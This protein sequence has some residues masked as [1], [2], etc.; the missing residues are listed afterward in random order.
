MRNSV[1]NILLGT[2]LLW[3]CTNRNNE[4]DNIQDSTDIELT[5]VTSDSLVVEPQISEEIKVVEDVILF[6]ATYRIL[7]STELQDKLASAKWK[8]IHKK[9][10]VYQ[11]A[12]AVY[13]LSKI[14]EDPCS[15]FPAQVIESNNK[16][17]L[18]FNIP[19]IKAG[20]VDTVAFTESM[21]KPNSP[22]SFTFNNKQFKLEAYGIEFYG[23]NGRTPKGDYTLKLFSEE[24]PQGKT[25][26]YQSSYNDTSTEL[27]MIAD[28][29]KD[30]LPDFIFSS[31]RD[32]EEERYLIILSSN[33]T[34]YEG[35]R[36]FD[37]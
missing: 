5:E 17:L 13:S 19:E 31:P 24:Y 22:F 28:F 10:G 16:A 30:G 27:V 11:V 9:D 33:G 7:N 3:S 37:C 12:D 35:D 2:S 8:E 23:A 34:T 36:Q 21:I 20:Q 14:N 18:L 32:Y 25:L 4:S 29:D 15:G 26:I 1:L 6:P